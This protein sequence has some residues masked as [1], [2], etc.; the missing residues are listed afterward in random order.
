MRLQFAAA[1]LLCAVGLAVPVYAQTTTITA[2]NAQ[3]NGAPITHGNISMWLTDGSGQPV[4]YATSAGVQQ[5]KGFTASITNGVVAAGL[6]VPDAC[7]V[8]SPTPGTALSYVAYLYNSDTQQSGIVNGI[9]GVC[10]TT[11]ALDP[12]LSG[13]VPTSAPTG[14]LGGSS[15]KM[16]TSCTQP[17][18]YNDTTLLQIKICDTTG[19]F[20]AAA[21][22]GGGAG[23]VLY[24]NGVLNPNQGVLGIKATGGATA[25]A[26]S[27]G[28]V[29]INVPASSG[30]AGAT[31]PAGPIGLTGST[32]ATGAQGPIGATGSQGIQGPIGATGP[33]GP[34][35]S[36]AGGS[37]TLLQ[38]D[39][40]TNAVQN[41]QNLISGSGI[42]VT[43]DANGGQT[44][45]VLNVP[46]SAVAAS[47]TDN[48]FEDFL[49]SGPNGDTSGALPAPAA[50][51]AYFRG[52]TSL[53]GIGGKGIAWSVDNSAFQPLLNAA[54]LLI[55]GANMPVSASYLGTNAAGQPI[56]VAAPS[57][58]GGAGPAGPTGATGATGQTGATGPQ[59]PAG[60][61]GATGAT[62]TAG[63]NGQA[64]AQGIQGATGLTGA[65]GATGATGPQ[66]PAG[67][68]GSG[69]FTEAVITSSTTA[70]PVNAAL[71]TV[72][73]SAAYTFTMAAGVAGPPQ[74]FSFC[75]G[76]TG[77]YAVTASGTNV[78]GFLLSNTNPN[79]C[80][81]YLANYYPSQGKWRYAIGTVSA[82]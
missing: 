44:V 12:Y 29:T 59:G 65:T 68:G 21:N 39:G 34:A 55:N 19:H 15:A 74:G 49:L 50:N 9:K 36:G 70:L 67:S 63:V 30:A 4:P 1:A 56:A 72:N 8:S 13:S 32:G 45:A 14:I 28:S 69:N 60:P 53:P 46:S 25:T 10:S 24:T 71:V 16:P 41:K 5:P 43:A 80:S 20:V 76:T 23:I 64:G 57:G 17:A 47:T 61:T 40:V 51:H 11:F 78:S 62:G 22:G 52:Y 54:G 75:Q 3:V 82:Q 73:L 18:S 58:T 42:K 77:G 48:G 26:A 79:T 38:T 35:G 33:T 2:S 6:Q 7:V 81:T 31:G 37:P 27:D 66:G